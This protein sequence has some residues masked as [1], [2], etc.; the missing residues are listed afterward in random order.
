MN[1]RFACHSRKRCLLNCQ[2]KSLARKCNGIL[3]ASSISRRRR[4]NFNIYQSCSHAGTTRS[5]R[6]SATQTS[7][8][9]LT[10]TLA[11]IDFAFGSIYFFRNLSLYDISAIFLNFAASLTPLSPPR[12]NCRAFLNGRVGSRARAR[13]TYNHRGN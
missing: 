2:L 10:Q 1:K 3:H 5:G 7:H 4:R 11:S 8:P 6:P 13:A 9:S 12:I